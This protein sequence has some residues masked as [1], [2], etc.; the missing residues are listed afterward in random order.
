MDVLFEE[1]QRPDYRDRS[2]RILAAVSFFVLTLLARDYIWTVWLPLFIELFRPMT[3]RLTAEC[4]RTTP[5]SVSCTVQLD[6]ILRCEVVEYRTSFWHGTIAPGMAFPSQCVRV[7]GNRGVRLDLTDGLHLVVG[8][9]EPER[10]AAA[11]LSRKA[12]LAAA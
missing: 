4:L 5:G 3:T 2:G 6:Q 11:I 7:R 10:L 12:V 9:Q 8:S 1:T